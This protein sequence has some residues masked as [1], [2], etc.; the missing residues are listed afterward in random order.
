MK[1]NDA[2]RKADEATS[3]VQGALEDVK[4]LMDE[5]SKYLRLTLHTCLLE[6]S[7]AKLINCLSP[8][9]RISSTYKYRGTRCYVGF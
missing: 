5:L 3:A 9:A 8:D 6:G 7:R 1:A 4:Q 2:K